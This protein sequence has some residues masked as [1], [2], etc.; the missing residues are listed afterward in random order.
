[1]LRCQL[2]M[3]RT[4]TVHPQELLFRC[5]KCR[6]CYVIRNTLPDTS[7]WYNVWGRTVLPQ[8]LY[9]WDVSGSAFRTTYHSLH[10]QHLKRSSC[11]WTVAVRNMW[12][13]HL[14][15]NKQSVLLHC[16]SRWNVYILQKMIHGPSNVKFFP[17]DFPTK[18]LYE[19]FFSPLHAT[20]PTHLILLD[21]IL[22]T[23]INIWWKVQI[24]NFLISQVAPLYYRRNKKQ[25]NP[26]RGLTGCNII[27][28]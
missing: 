21:L 15:I 22:I 14:S 25:G 1:M 8:M 2:H 3:F 4:A 6:L 17:S 23:Q 26:F 10:I 20:Y 11:G 16:V 24:M 13:W 7:H 28:F 19:F 12:S 9:Q 5:C 27:L 18:T